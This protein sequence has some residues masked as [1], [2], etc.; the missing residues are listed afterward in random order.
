MMHNKLRSINVTSATSNG[1]PVLNQDADILAIQEHIVE[2]GAAAKLEAAAKLWELQQC[3]LGPVDPENTRK[4]AGVCFLVKE[5]ISLMP[6]QPTNSDYTG[7]VSPLCRIDN[8][9]LVNFQVP[10]AVACDTRACTVAAHAYRWQ[11]TRAD[12]E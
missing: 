2:A 12:G 1:T 3:F 6:I 11:R 4:S 5:G 9:W 10:R 7:A 8:H